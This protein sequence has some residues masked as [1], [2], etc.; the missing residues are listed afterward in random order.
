MT[1]HATPTKQKYMEYRGSGR[2]KKEFSIDQITEFFSKKEQKNK[3]ASKPGGSRGRPLVVSQLPVMAFLH[4]TPLEYSP[5]SS[6]TKSLLCPDSHEN[7][8]DW[9]PR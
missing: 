4:G 5:Y 9:L 6:D 3:W 2:I 1:E 8:T 7:L